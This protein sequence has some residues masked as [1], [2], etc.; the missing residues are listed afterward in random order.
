[1]LKM[2]TPKNAIPR[3]EVIMVTGNVDNPRTS[4]RQIEKP[5]HHIVMF[6]FPIARQR[7]PVV[8]DITDEIDRLSIMRLQEIEDQTCT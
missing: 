3:E 4:P 2:A 5:P 1:M 7:V 8:N 6:R